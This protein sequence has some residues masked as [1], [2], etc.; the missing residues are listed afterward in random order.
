VQHSI[1]ALRLPALLAVHRRLLY[2]SENQLWDLLA[3]HEGE[4][5]AS[6]QARALGAEPCTF[7]EGCRAALEL[8]L[9]YA[10]AVRGLVVDAEELAVIEGA[11]ELAA[12]GLGQGQRRELGQIQSTRRVL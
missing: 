11:C 7:E 6:A 12:I 2:G 1:I 10:D 3:E 5:W 9:L 8:Y 4:P